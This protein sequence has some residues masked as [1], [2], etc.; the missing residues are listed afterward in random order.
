[1]RGAIAAFVAITL[2]GAPLRAEPAP[3]SAATSPD[4]NDNARAEQLYRDGLA[5]FDTA[6]YLE[7]IRLWSEAYRILPNTPESADIKRY[8]TNNLAVA[9]EK[10]FGI[11][12]DVQHLKRALDLAQNYRDSIAALY[13]DDPRGEQE[14]ARTDEFLARVQA[15]VD[16]AERKQAPAPPPRVE[17]SAKPTRVDE[18]TKPTHAQGRGAIIGGSVLLGLGGVTGALLITGVAIGRAANDVDPDESMQAR[19]EQFDRGRAGNKL[20]IAGAVLTPLLLAAGIALVVVGAKRR[21]ASRVALTPSGASL[22]F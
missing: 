12:G 17:P 13:G 19:G 8:L 7:A 9:R 4:A 10:Q 21:K 22:R 14:R 2:C 15:K 16:E 1:M 3:T 11:D 18:P 20:A 6:E 5:A